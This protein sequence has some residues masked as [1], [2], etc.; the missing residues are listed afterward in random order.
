MP[1][2]ILCFLS[3]LS[4]I[5]SKLAL[6]LSTDLPQVR[7]ESDL[8]FFGPDAPT[9]AAKQNVGLDAVEEQA[10]SNRVSSI[11]EASLMASKADIMA[12]TTAMGTACIVKHSFTVSLSLSFLPLGCLSPP[13]IF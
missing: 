3:S 4:A 9:P 7:A 2:C 6:V 1:G 5:L 10:Y 12:L 8:S 11:H 13:M